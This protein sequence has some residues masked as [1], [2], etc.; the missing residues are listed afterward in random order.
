[1]LT[2][3]LMSGPGS[4]NAQSILLIKGI[5]LPTAATDEEETFL[6]KSMGGWKVRDNQ[7][8]IGTPGKIRKALVGLLHT[9]KVQEQSYAG[10]AKALVPEENQQPRQNTPKI[11]LKL[12]RVDIEMLQNSFYEGVQR[13]TEVVVKGHLKETHHLG[14]LDHVGSQNVGRPNLD[15]EGGPITPHESCSIQRLNSARSHLESILHGRL[16]IFRSPGI[17]NLI[18]FPLTLV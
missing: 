9:K 18:N 5:I 15:T 3:I 13:E 12:R 1:M 11:G 6:P 16:Q 17:F 7:K 8:S 2:K 10:N 4:R 14:H